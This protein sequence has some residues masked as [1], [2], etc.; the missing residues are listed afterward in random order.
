[1]HR[2]TQANICKIIIDKEK[3]HAA[4]HLHI[5]VAA[6]WIC[7]FSLELETLVEPSK[8]S[9]LFDQLDINCMTLGWVSLFSDQW[10]MRKSSE[11]K[12]IAF[13]FDKTNAAKHTSA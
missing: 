5:Y 12:K 10:L 8:K 3:V 4:W 9:C 2:I 7:V 1:M 11:K 13:P 6:L